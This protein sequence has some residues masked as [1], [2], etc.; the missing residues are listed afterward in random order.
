MKTTKSLVKTIVTASLGLAIATATLIVSPRLLASGGNNGGG[1]GVG[2]QAPT[3]SG[4]WS[5]TISTPF[6]TGAFTMRISQSVT[7]LSGSVHFGA[8]IFD[9][10]LKF[11]ASSANLIQ[12]NGLVANGEGTLP[13]TGTISANGTTMTGTVIQLGK[14]YTYFVTRN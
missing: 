3:F 8:P 14:T 4:N 6:G 7:S 2:I 11:A 1:G 9:A 10:T 5:G 12:F 13:I